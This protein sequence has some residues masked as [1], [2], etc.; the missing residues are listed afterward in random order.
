MMYSRICC[1]TRPERLVVSMT[2][3]AWS[4][5]AIALLIYNYAKAEFI[6]PEDRPFPDAI[7]KILRKIL[8]NASS[9]FIHQTSDKSISNEGSPHA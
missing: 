8:R 7:N 6:L 4:C 5:F 2:L 1:S 9:V 3:K